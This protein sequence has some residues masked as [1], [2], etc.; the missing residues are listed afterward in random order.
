LRSDK[1]EEE[2][3]IVQDRIESTKEGEGKE[4]LQPKNILERERVNEF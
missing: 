3:K 2:F 4:K 1:G